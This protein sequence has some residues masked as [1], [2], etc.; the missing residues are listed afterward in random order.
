M[1]LLLSWCNFSQTRIFFY[2][3]NRGSSV[4]PH[5]QIFF[6]NTKFFLYCSSVGVIFFKHDIFF[7]ATIEVAVLLLTSRLFFMHE[8]FFHPTR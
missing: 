2:G 3:D 8:N 6:L 4:A 7:M 1:L 5:F